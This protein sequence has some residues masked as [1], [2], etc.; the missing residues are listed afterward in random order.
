MT[1]HY[2]SDFDT[3]AAEYERYR[4]SYSD[5]LFDAIVAYAG[6]LRGRRVAPSGSFAVKGKEYL[7][8]G[9]RKRRA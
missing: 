8:L 5:S 9:R 7:F 2:R 4:T 6:P 1:V 3:L